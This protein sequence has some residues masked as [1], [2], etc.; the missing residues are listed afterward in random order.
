MA[1]L[2]HDPVEV[3]RNKDG[4]PKLADDTASTPG[5]GTF[6][7][8]E[9]Y[10]FFITIDLLFEMFFNRESRLFRYIRLIYF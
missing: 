8:D 1:N 7:S 4:T 3:P 5:R 2:S 9:V 6:F 10:S